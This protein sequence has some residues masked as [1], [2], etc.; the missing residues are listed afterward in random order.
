MRPSLGD[1]IKS[2]TLSVPVCPFSLICSKLESRRNLKFR[3]HD[4]NTSNWESKFDVKR[5]KVEIT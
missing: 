3:G 5:S 4:T 1:G 2:Y